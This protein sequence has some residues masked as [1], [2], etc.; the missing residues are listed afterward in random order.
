MRLVEAAK[1]TFARHETFPPRYGW[2]RKAY[3]FVAADPHVF[4]REDAPV[5]V[6]VGKNMV[7][8]IRFW[9][10]AAK[11]IEV[12]QR[13]SNRR[14]PGLVPTRWGHTIF[15]ELGWDRYME[16]PGTLWLL[17]W[18]LLAPPS[19][20]PVWWLAFNE[21]HA[22]EFADGDLEGAVTT[23][24]EAVAEWNAP[25]PSSVVKDVSVLLRTY[26]PAER[27]GRS[28]IEDVLDCP[29]RELNLIGRSVATNRY[30]FTLGAKP[31]LPPAVLAYA[32]LD[33]IARIDARG[34]TV[35]LGRLAN[36]PGAP[37]RAFKLTEDE[38][39]AA[40]ESLAGETNA[41]ALT[42]SMGTV[43]LSWSGEPS[44]VATGMLDRYFRCS[45]SDNRADHVAYAHARWSPAASAAGR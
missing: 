25:H 31:T 5:R 21:F 22:V 38:L 9:G 36:D 10:L 4:S 7:R 39:L 44:E 16:D 3:T 14:N 1:P 32:A 23:Q 45:L 11:L 30:R 29:L 40:L 43:Q 15:G 35:T 6:G 20:L 28:G 37:G 19:L 17:H 24:L 34:N 41:L 2:F 13:S 33:Y 18:M 12:D 42:T 26:A 8:A 27:S